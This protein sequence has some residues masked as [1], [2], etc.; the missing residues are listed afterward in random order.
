MA[1]SGRPVIGSFTRYLLTFV[2]GLAVGALAG[3]YFGPMLEQR[4]PDLKPTS[5]PK[6]PPT[7]QA[8]PP[9]APTGSTG[10]TGAT[11]PIGAQTPSGAPK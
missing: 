6:A 9:P 1:E 2:A 8:T 4:T 5:P 10:N 3:V 7:K 11:G